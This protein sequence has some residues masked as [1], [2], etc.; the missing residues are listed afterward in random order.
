MK[1]TTYAVIMTII[2]MFV[3]ILCIYSI[4]ANIDHDNYITGMIEECAVTNNVHQSSCEIRAVNTTVERS[5]DK[6]P[7]LLPPLQKTI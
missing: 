3:S 1:T 6:D 7:E 4:R 2:A 5:V